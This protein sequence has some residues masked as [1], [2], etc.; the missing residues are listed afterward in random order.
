[1]TETRSQNKKT[2]T[3]RLKIRKRRKKM[4]FTAGPESGID[5]SAS[6][7]ALT[8]IWLSRIEFW[9]FFPFTGPLSFCE[10]TVAVHQDLDLDS[11]VGG[12]STYFHLRAVIFSSRFAERKPPRAHL[13]ICLGLALSLNPASLSD[14]CQHFCLSVFFSRSIK[15]FNNSPST[16]SLRLVHRVSAS[17]SVARFRALALAR[18]HRNAAGKER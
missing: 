3:R 15:S 7:S 12:G 8:Q 14:F 10:E 11:R 1:M 5:G 2:K 9:G 6:A 4:F 16:S 17:L 13:A 18:V